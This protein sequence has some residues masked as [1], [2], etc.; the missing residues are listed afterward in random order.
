LTF[1]L[2]IHIHLSDDYGEQVEVTKSEIHGLSYLTTL[3]K[4]SV[5]IASLNNK[6]ISESKRKLFEGRVLKNID[7]LYSLQKDNAAYI[8]KDFNDLLERLKQ[9]N[10][11]TQ[12]YYNTIE[13]IGLENYRVG[14]ASKLLFEKDRKIYFLSSL[15]THYMPEYL[16][17]TL[18]NRN[19][20]EELQVDV[21]HSKEEIFKEQRKLISLSAEEIYAIIKVIAKYEDTRILLTYM[22]N[23]MHKRASLTE[24]VDTKLLFEGD[25]QMIEKYL[26]KV[27]EIL[28]ESYLL[29]NTYIKII[30]SNLYKRL[31]KLNNEILYL[32]LTISIIALFLS[33]LFLYAYKLYK[34]REVQ[35]KNLLQEQEKTKDALAFKSRFLSNMS[36]EIRTPLNTIIGLTDVI[37]KTDL[38]AKQADILNK[39]NGAGEILL[40]VINDI[41]DI[42]KIESGKLH[43][44]SHEFELQKI[45]SDIKDMFTE[46]ARERNNQIKVKYENIHNFHRIGDSLRIS[47][48]LINFISNSI[49]FTQNGEIILTIKGAKVGDNI[50]FEVLDTGIGIKKEYLNAL[51]EEFTQADM[52]TTRK[53]GGTGL[54]LAISKNLVD[55]M[56]GKITVSSEYGYGSTFSFTIELPATQETNTKELAIQK[57]EDL[58]MEVNELEGITLL[59][60]EDNKMNQT[61]LGMLLEDSQLNLEYADDGEMAVEMAKKKDYDLILMDIQMPKLNGYEAT[62]LIREFNS[63]VPILALS[64]NVMQED[65]DKSLNSG[66]NYHLAK[67]INMEKLY[68]QLIRFLKP[69][70]K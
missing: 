31:D 32:N 33:M 2:T 7:F 8:D 58:E 42:A 26:T 14:D 11:S 13:L 64:A 3:Y 12:E 43:I 56:G 20:V 16:V 61:L 62:K 44:E 59:I 52:N 65:I 49:K 41:L 5:N 60:A 57:L 25:K 48:I 18:I 47:Q 70:K 53:Y 67:P 45:I 23:I 1:I 46:K 69:Q 66:M 51:F 38:T 39:I 35:H 15:S 21:S 19:I 40:G 50:T 9:F 6:N 37:K 28:Y 54:G 4:L 27:D 24:S 17:N 29:N 10:M 36:H 68:K 22:N 55:M 34:S 30:E 63:T